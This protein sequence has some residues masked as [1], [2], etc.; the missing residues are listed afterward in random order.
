MENN[1]YLVF[2]DEQGNIWIRK[3]LDNGTAEETLIYEN[4]CF[5]FESYFKNDKDKNLKEKI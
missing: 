4:K 5:I 3:Y 1:N 2:T